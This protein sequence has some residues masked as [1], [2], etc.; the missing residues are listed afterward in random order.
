MSD[1]PVTDAA[2]RWKRLYARRCETGL[3][4]LLLEYP[5]DSVDPVGGGYGADADA[6]AYFR[7]D[8]M[9]VVEAADHREGDQALG[10][11]V[12]HPADVDASGKS[13]HRVHDLVLQGDVSA[14]A[15]VP[16]GGRIRLVRA[17]QPGDGAHHTR[18]G[19]LYRGLVPPQDPMNDQPFV[20]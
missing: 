17:L 8:G 3:Y 11:R 2:D 6:D 12:V 18:P 7:R 13:V 14:P 4:P 9:V 19:A 1:G 5:D 16:L 15:V 20:R 10:L